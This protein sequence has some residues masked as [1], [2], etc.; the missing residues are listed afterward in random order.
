MKND[1]VG[2]IYGRL[3]VI[4]ID[5]EKSLKRKRKFYLCECVCG[6]VTSVYK[7]HLT[8]GKISSCG[9]LRKER[10]NKIITRHGGSKTLLYRVWKGMI[11]RCYYINHKS[12][13]DYGG[14][15]IIV[16]YEW[17]ENF[18]SFENWSLKNGYEKGLTLYRID[19]NG[20]YEPSNCRWITRKEQ[21]L[22]KRNTIY[23]TIGNETKTLMEWAECL[24]VK[25]STLRDR[26]RRKKF[27]PKDT[28]T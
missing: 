27:P 6:K 19:N 5:D 9:C 8:N 2:K 22:N 25:L 15:G 18:K 1:I 26:Y 11:E 17:K 24:G 23:I 12:Y 20:N 14:R 10:F 16:C 4:K 3:K 21:N 28:T 7:H 13:K